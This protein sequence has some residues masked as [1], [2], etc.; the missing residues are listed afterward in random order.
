MHKLR[1]LLSTLQTPSPASR[2]IPSR[3]AQLSEACKKEWEKDGSFGAE[4]EK[5]CHSG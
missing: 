1:H 4:C 5:Q 3:V 2:S